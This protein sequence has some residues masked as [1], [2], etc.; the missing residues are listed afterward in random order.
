MTTPTLGP[1]VPQMP[2]Y[3]LPVEFEWTKYDD[4]EGNSTSTETGYLYLG[5]QTNH[6]IIKGVPAVGDVF[7][8]NRVEEWI[9]FSQTGPDPLSLGE[10]KV[11]WTDTDGIIGAAGTTYE[12][13]SVFSGATAGQLETAIENAFGTGNVSVSKTSSSPDT[14]EIEFIGD[15]A[16]NN[17]FSLTIEV[18]YYDTVPSGFEFVRTELQEG[19]PG[20]I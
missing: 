11:S 6:P 9:P 16:G 3:G 5:F 20:G 14:Y 7:P 8:V 13:S 10:F 18:T 19:S 12:S 2:E 17:N 15:L 4:P 1:V